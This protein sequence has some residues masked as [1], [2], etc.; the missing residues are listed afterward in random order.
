MMFAKHTMLT[1]FA[2]ATAL[3]VAATAQAQQSPT[4]NGQAPTQNGQAA[5]GQAQAQ[6]QGKVITTLEPA[7]M[8]PSIPLPDK[9]PGR[10]DNIPAQGSNTEYI[11]GPS[12]GSVPGGPAFPGGVAPPTSQP[13]QTQ[14]GPGYY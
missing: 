2:V 13:D 1:G 3:V 11:H 14:R 10:R 4:Q 7:P 9:T 5:T 12:E 8:E 6:Q